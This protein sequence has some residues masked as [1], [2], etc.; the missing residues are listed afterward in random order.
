MAEE[1]WH[2]ARLIPTTGISGADEQERRGTSALLA[3]LSAVREFGKSVTARLDAPAGTIETFIEVPFDLNGKRV[4]PDGLIR[5]TRGQRSWVAL[6]EVKT[7]KNDLR[8]EQLECY[9]DVA[10]EQGFN[11]L[12]SISNEIPTAS[13][14][15]PTAVDKRKLRK[16]AL[17]HLSWSQIHT[18]AIMHKVN[19]SVSDP[20]QAYIL[21]EFI[22]YLEHPKSGLVDFDDMGTSWVTVRDAI[23]AGTVR[24]TD[25]GV[26]EVAAKWEQLVRY[27]GMRLGRQL[28]IE[29]LPAL[30]RRDLANPGSRMQEQ[31]TSL[32][33]KGTLTG[34]LRVPNT[35][36]PVVLTADLRAGQVSASLSVDAPKEGR[37]LTRINWLLR[38]L[39]DAPDDLRIDAFTPWSRGTSRSDLLRKVR[40]DPSLLLDEQK[41]EIRSF[42]L[43]LSKSSGSKRGQGKGSFVGS[44]LDLLDSFY[45]GVVQSVK[46][47]SP[48]PPKLR[49]PEPGQLTEPNIPNEL[50]STALSSQDD[51]AAVSGTTD[52]PTAGEEV[53]GSP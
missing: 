2:A 9:L 46:G 53:L 1:S 21:S 12:L 47:W 32:V 25:K 31:M 6:V 42:T 35:V 40:E 52:G 48:A 10:R 15:H 37:P 23:S 5:V 27:A 4:Y 44:V 3:V 39:K 8:A 11:A 50:V 38:Q 22:R 33:S 20:D 49:Q 29:V 43:T 30:S 36:G 13:G 45:K 18:E 14:V 16:V 26:T 28:G 19:S 7:G 41:R 17:H 24:A 34:S 51:A